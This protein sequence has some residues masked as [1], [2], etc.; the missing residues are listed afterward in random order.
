MHSILVVEDNLGLQSLIVKKLE[1]HNFSVIVSQS[2][3]KA[4]ELLASKKIEVVWLDH[5]LLGNKNGFDLV[6]DMKKDNSGYKNIPIFVVA[7]SAD[8]EKTNAYLR[9]GVEKYYL[10]SGVSLNNIIA[11]I[12]NFLEK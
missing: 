5:Y 4:L 3:E 11:E 2:V 6:V 10:K 12:N 9:M 8:N 1:Q 7:N